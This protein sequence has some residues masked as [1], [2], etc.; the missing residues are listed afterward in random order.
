MLLQ[1]IEYIIECVLRSNFS[2]KLLYVV[3]YEQ[4]DALIEVDEVVGLVVAHS[5]C[6]L[7]LKH[8]R[9]DVK[10]TQRRVDFL[11]L[12]PNCLHQVGL[13]HSG[14]PKQE[15][16]VERLALRIGGYCHAYAHR[17]LVAHASAIILKCII[18][19]ELWVD[20]GNTILNKRIFRR[21]IRLLEHNRRTVIFRFFAARQVVTIIYVYVTLKNS[22]QCFLEQIAE[23]LF[24]LFNEIQRRHL[25]IQAIALEVECHNRLEPSFKL[26]GRQIVFYHF[27]TTIP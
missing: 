6:I 3:E 14:G 26:L 11:C 23:L 25:K 8:A 1:M 17:Q 21:V 20:V 24:D 13:A 19:I 2:G 9:G 27:K 16:R 4:I 5:C 7:A 18:G 12:Q 22:L 10:H 15:H